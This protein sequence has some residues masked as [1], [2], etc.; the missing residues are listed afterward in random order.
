LGTKPRSKSLP[1]NL[2]AKFSGNNKPPIITS[3][4]NEILLWF[5]SDDT[6]TGKGWE[7]NYSWV[8]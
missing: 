2:I 4:S 6:I 5:I 8:D 1:D 3:S 7:I